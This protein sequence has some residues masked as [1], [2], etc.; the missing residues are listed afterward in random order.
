MN[1]NAR[2]FSPQLTLVTALSRFLQPASRLASSPCS[3]R[4]GD[5]RED[6]GGTTVPFTRPV[7]AR[8]SGDRKLLRKSE[9]GLLAEAP[10]V[11]PT[12]VELDPLPDST[13]LRRA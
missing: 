8:G 6:S 2:L 11:E 3:A 10:E 1:I 7:L 13:E 5:L 4:R 9:S 12:E